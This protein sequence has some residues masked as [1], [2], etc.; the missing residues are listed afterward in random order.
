MK[1]ILFTSSLRRGISFGAQTVLLLILSFIFRTEAQAQCTPSCNTTN[2]SIDTNCV[3]VVTRDMVGTL[4][5]GCTGSYRINLRASM[6]GPVLETVDNGNLLV[7]GID[8]N[9]DPYDF[10]NKSMVLELVALDGTPPYN[11]CWNWHRFEDKLP[12]IIHCGLDTVPCYVDYRFAGVDPDDCSGP[13]TVYT[14]DSLVEELNCDAYPGLLRRIV[15]EFYAEDAVGNK[16]AVCNDTVYIARPDADSLNWPAM[17]TLYCDQN[18]AKDGNGNPSPSVSGFPTIGAGHYPLWP[19]GIEACG[20]VTSYSDRVIPFSCT[21]KVM[22]TWTI[23]E[24]YCGIDYTYERVQVIVIRDTTPPVLTVPD[25]VTISSTTNSCSRDFYVPQATA[26][27][28]CQT[29]LNWKVTW[30]GGYKNQNGGFTL[31]LPVGRHVFYYNVNDGCNNA[32]ADSMVVTVVDDVAP[33]AICIENTVATIPNGSEFVRVPAASFD[34]GSWD[35]CGPVTFKVRRMNPDCYP[36]LDKYVTAPGYDY[37]DFYCCDVGAPLQVILRVIDQSGNYSECMVNITIQDKSAPTLVCPPDWGIYCDQVNNPYNPHPVYIDWNDLGATFGRIITDG[38]PSRKGD[39]QQGEDIFHNINL[40]GN[41]KDNCGVDVDED[42]TIDSSSCGWRKI[43]RKFTVTDPGGLSRTCTQ[44]INIYRSPLYL[45]RNYFAAPHDTTIINGTCVVDGLDP[46]DLGD[47]YR[48]RFAYYNDSISNCYDLAYNYRDEVYHIVDNA[49]FKILRY[50]TIIDWCY[51]AEYG[52]DEALATAVKFTQVIKVMNNI[53][54]TFSP[55]ADFEVCSN[56]L[57][58]ESELVT[59]TASAND[60]CT[61]ANL[62]KYEWR[63]DLN[64]SV[65]GVPTWDIYGNGNTISRELPLGVHKIC[66]YATDGCANV[67][68]ECFVVTVKNCKKPS[69][70]A[71]RLVTEIMPSSGNI[72]LPARYFDAG[73][74]SSCGGPVRFSYSSNVNDT[75]RTWDCDDIGDDPPVTVEFWVTDQWG[76]QDYVLVTIVI[77]DNNGVCDDQLR[78]RIAGQILTPNTEGIPRIDVNAGSGLN[79]KTS[80]TGDYKFSSIQFGDTYIVKPTSDIDPLNGVE[81]G[82]IVKIQNHI[83]GKK[84]IDD[85]YK[86][87]AAD[88]TMDN[89]IKGSDV[90]EMRKLILGKSTAFSSNRSWRFVDKKYHFTGSPFASSFPEQI[91]VTPMETLN[92]IDFYGVKLGDVNGNVKLSFNDNNVEVRSGQKLEFTAKY[93]VLPVGQPLDVRF[94]IDQIANIDGFQ[95]ALQTINGVTIKGIR[96]N[97]IN[98]TDDNYNILNPKNARLSWTSNGAKNTEG[99][100]TVTLVAD[101]PVRLSQA[102]HLNDT[103]MKSAGYGTDDSNY[104]VEVRFGDEAGKGVVVYQNRPNPFS[105]ATVIGFN[106]PEPMD[107]TVRIHDL[108]GKTVYNTTQT[109]GAGDNEVNISADKLGASGVFIY[110]VSTKYGTEMKRMILIKN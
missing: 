23:N 27:D 50:W 34:N 69:P 51:A 12:P 63:I 18:Y 37:L 77:Q 68:E 42:V 64:Y 105:N 49:C 76:N 47:L 32:E 38:S 11:Y 70:V 56:D 13:I 65:S 110:E 98:F 81:T 83:L 31:N 46:D 16:S 87:I 20:M 58:C 90:I 43:T 91:S 40:D 10:I 88:V 95:M 39:V 52:I 86:M 94:H 36:D 106:L 2:I 84:L 102:I 101:S 29:S 99:T 61:P 80:N 78:E 24:W 62:L 75:L 17:D 45:H 57:T 48:P 14:L 85:P 97:D 107:V 74:F 92:G 35:N 21:K 41:S 25:D 100:I 26:T 15:R 22:R 9:G 5:P 89:E 30:T 59:V 60:D 104:Q 103:D 54:P 93:Q 79:T 96:S 82:D 6:S 28:N 1:E 4:P 67:S 71:H 44:V 33:N 7:D 73:S 3:A 109:Y 8:G 66:F 72:T 55:I 19:N 108:N 53:A